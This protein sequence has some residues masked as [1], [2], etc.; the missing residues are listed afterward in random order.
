MDG[1]LDLPPLGVWDL[2]VSPGPSSVHARTPTRGSG[3]VACHHYRWTKDDIQDDCD[4]RRHAHSVL[5]T[6][7]DHCTPAIRGKTTTSTPPLMCAAPPCDYKRGGQALSLSR[8][9][10]LRTLRRSGHQQP[11][12]LTHA[13]IATLK[14]LF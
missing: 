8:S 11:R 12:S 7:S 14:P 10:A 2:H 3:A 4:A 5:P 9:L 1:V 6:V 13:I